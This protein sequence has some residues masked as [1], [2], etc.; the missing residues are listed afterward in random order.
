MKAS[1]CQQLRVVKCFSE[2]I[3]RY[4]SKPVNMFIIQ[5]AYS[6]PMID[7]ENPR[8]LN[9]NAICAGIT[10]KTTTLFL[11]EIM[12]RT[13]KINTTL[14]HIERFCRIGYKKFVADNRMPNDKAT[15]L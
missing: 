8:L 11:N 13:S 4:Q 14:F 6:L 5:W 1:D 2:E 7:R 12:V 9:V 3:K 15:R 10:F